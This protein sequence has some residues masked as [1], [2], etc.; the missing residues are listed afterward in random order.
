MN[1]VSANT[2]Q[3]WLL[4]DNSEIA[5]L[6]V[7]EAGEYGIGHLLFATSVPYSVLELE[8]ARQVPNRSVR[9]V[10]YDDGQSGVAERAAQR[11]A[12]LGYEQ[13][14]VLEGGT[15]AWQSAG[16]RLF[17]GVNVPSKVFGELVEEARHTPHITADSLNRML[18]SQEPVVVVDGR[19][20][21]EY[22]KMNIPGS[23]CCPNGELAY[24]ISALVPDDKT[25]VVVN[26][27][28]RTRSIIG[29]QTLRE[30][31]IIPNPVYALEN[32]TQGWALAGFSLEHGSDRRYPDAV[33]VRGS[34]DRQSSAIKLAQNYGVRC[35]DWPEAYAWLGDTARTTY[36]LDVRTPEEFSASS[37]P[38]AQ[39]APGGQ[40]IQATDHWLAVRGAR[41]LLIDY[42][43]IRAPIV[44]QWLQRMGWDAHIVKANEDPE[45]GIPGDRRLNQVWPADLPAKIGTDQLEAWMGTGECLAVDIRPSMDFRDGHIPDSVWSIRPKI[46]QAIPRGTRRVVLI[47]NNEAMIR[48]AMSELTDWHGTE[49]YYL[50]GGYDRWVEEG[51]TVSSSP[52][53]P[54]DEDAIDYL[55]FVHDR[56]DGNLEAARQ[57]L[58]WELG[59]VAQLEPG[60]LAKFNP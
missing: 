47:A 59:L 38:G 58:A 25:P 48:L 60:E 15:G 23:I 29:A 36:F 24:R 57:Y 52:D 56:H 46:A 19:P 28:G 3:T 9:L 55:F 20:F 12:A 18:Q 7:R 8:L 50:D 27:A 54:S 32:G 53:I 2:L 16:F 49:F 6:D 41:I 51:R 40:L 30:L 13:I 4:D 33:P 1:T 11:V 31:G 5:V 42:D 21:H 34:D 39:N 22:Q 14:F 45:M 37:V 43:G 17:A 35:L 10:L 44:A 26:C